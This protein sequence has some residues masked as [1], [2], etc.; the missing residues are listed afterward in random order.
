LPLRP[1]PLAAFLAVLALAAC[2]RQAP[3]PITDSR[4]ERGTALPPPG[5]SETTAR[6]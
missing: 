6:R 4:I 2:G 5:L 1:V 3:S